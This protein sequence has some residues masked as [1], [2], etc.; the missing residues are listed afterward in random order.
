MTRITVVYDTFAA[1]LH[2]WPRVRFT[3][4]WNYGLGGDYLPMDRALTE[5]D[6]GRWARGEVKEMEFAEVRDAPHGPDYYY[7]RLRGHECQSITEARVRILVKDKLDDLRDPKTVARAFELIERLERVALLRRAS[8][9]RQLKE[10]REKAKLP[11][12]RERM[13]ILIRGFECREQSHSGGSLAIG[14]SVVL[15]RIRDVLM[16]AEVGRFAD[17]RKAKRR[18]GSWTYRERRG[19]RRLPLEFDQADKAVWSFQFSRSLARR[20]YD[21]LKQ[22]MA[23]PGRGE[24]WGAWRDDIAYVPWRC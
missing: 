16:D 12:V 7:S 23:P 6:L 3:S 10:T 13:D 15:R 11:E 19:Y 2:R 21:R 14:I 18:L 5:D 22:D 24:R 4:Q 8:T 17:L 9:L 1:G 20:V